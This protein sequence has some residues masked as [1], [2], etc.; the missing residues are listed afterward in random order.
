MASGAISCVY[1]LSRGCV[2]VW[3]TGRLYELFWGN[4]MKNI[5]NIDGEHC[6]AK[7]SS[8]AEAL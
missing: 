5:G 1:D 3:L 6:D 8:I 2:V 4:D 7:I